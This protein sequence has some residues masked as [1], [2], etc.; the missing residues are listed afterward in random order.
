MSKKE[1]D[2]D[3]EVERLSR[4]T[5]INIKRT[6][7][8]YEKQIKKVDTEIDKVINQKIKDFD[9]YKDELAKYLTID[10]S[11]SS[12]DEYRKRLNKI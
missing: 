7:Y 10:Y 9:E 8:A 5:N 1:V 2:I 11:S 4:K 3:E 12:V 6:E